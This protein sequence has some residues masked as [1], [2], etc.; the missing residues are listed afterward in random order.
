MSLR[1]SIHIQE[2]G[3][4]NSFLMK[5]ALFYAKYLHILENCITFVAESENK[6]LLGIKR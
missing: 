3:E 5:V 6:L 4:K 1:S 2:R